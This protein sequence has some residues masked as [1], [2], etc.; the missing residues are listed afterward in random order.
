[1]KVTNPHRWER[2]KL[3]ALLIL[4][5]TAMSFGGGLNEDSMEPIPDFG[6]AI[7]FGSLGILLA[8]RINSTGGLD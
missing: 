7:F 6:L 8:T 5:I 2:T 4:F 1:M 3:V